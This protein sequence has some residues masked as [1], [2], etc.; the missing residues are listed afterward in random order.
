MTI[1]MC[2]RDAVLSHQSTLVAM[3]LVM[4]ILLCHPQ[5]VESKYC[6][7]FCYL[8]PCHHCS[9]PAMLALTI[10]LL[11]AITFQKVSSAESAPE[12]PDETMLKLASDCNILQNQ[13]R[14]NPVG[15]S[16]AL[17]TRGYT[18]EAEILRSQSAPGC[19]KLTRSR[20]L[21]FASQEHVD[22]LQKVN[23]SSFYT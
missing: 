16:Y 13:A 4:S 2:H 20:G 7:C 8:L 3:E 5:P 10:M 1:S 19:L 11:L 6:L 17:R 21:D 18:E 9:L 15:F 14:V 23:P 22:M 12:G